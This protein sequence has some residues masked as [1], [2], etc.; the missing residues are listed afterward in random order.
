ML[1]INVRNYNTFTELSSVTTM[2]DT[3]CIVGVVDIKTASSVFT[4]DVCASWVDF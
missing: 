4:G 3:D 2:T 1:T